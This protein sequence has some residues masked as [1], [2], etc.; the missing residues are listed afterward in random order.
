M[1]KGDALFSDSVGE[2]KSSNQYD[3]TRHTQGT[4][5]SPTNM[6]WSFAIAERSKIRTRRLRSIFW[7]LI[8]LHHIFTWTDARCMH[9]ITLE[10]QLVAA[11]VAVPKTDQ[12]AKREMENMSTW[13]HTAQ[14]SF[15]PVR[16]PCG[17]E[18]A[19]G[20]P[21]AIAVRFLARHPAQVE[22]WWS[23]HSHRVAGT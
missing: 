6:R 13:S 5:R 23:S 17:S 7:D 2:Q 18:R 15:C 4:H 19:L 16:S 22:A 10:K 9:R 12:Q 8:I 3:P 1:G 11:Y 14:V 21:T 20:S